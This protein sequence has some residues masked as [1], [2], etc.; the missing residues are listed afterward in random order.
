MFS[1]WWNPCIHFNKNKPILL[2]LELVRSVDT[3]ANNVK[4]VSVE[5]LSFKEMARTTRKHAPWTSK[6]AT[7]KEIAD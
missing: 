1:R 7:K 6:K 2:F 4:N 5:V 3:L